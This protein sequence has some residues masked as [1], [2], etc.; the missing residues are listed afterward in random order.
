MDE[1]IQVKKSSFAHGVERSYSLMNKV[2]PFPE[3][4]RP[5]PKRPNCLTRKLIKIGRFPALH[6]EISRS[7]D[8]I[9]DEAKGEEKK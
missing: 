6:Y 1:N 7:L 9:L 3:R 8:E 4:R 2:I 5:E